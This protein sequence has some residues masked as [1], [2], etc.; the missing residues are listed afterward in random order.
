[1]AACNCA[2]VSLLVSH[3]VVIFESTNA[4]KQVKDRTTSKP[5]NVM[6]LIQVFLLPLPWIP[7]NGFRSLK[8]VIRFV[9]NQ[10]VE[11]IFSFSTLTYH[12]EMFF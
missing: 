8:T 7:K 2:M 6:F 10:N 9:I 4:N 11:E 5:A 1:M 3:L 12:D